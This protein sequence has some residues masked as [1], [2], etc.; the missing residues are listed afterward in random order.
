MDPGVKTFL[1]MF[2]ANM[3]GFVLGFLAFRMRKTSGIAC[4][5]EGTDRIVAISHDG[6]TIMEL[7]LAPKPSPVPVGDPQEPSNA[8]EESE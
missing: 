2:F 4:R 3:V 8:E 5:V 6:R 7:E 1:L